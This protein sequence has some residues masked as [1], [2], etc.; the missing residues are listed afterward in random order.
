ME[1]GFA[2]NPWAFHKNHRETAL[3]LAKKLGCQAEDP[4]Q[5][6]QYLLN[7]PANEL[8]KCSKKKDTFEVCI[9]NLYSS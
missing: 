3:K 5:I 7:V 9:S 4:K 2:L 1:S 8:V 6:L